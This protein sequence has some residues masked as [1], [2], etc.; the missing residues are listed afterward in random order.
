MSV[1]KKRKIWYMIF[2]GMY[3]ALG[4]MTYRMFLRQAIS[5]P[6]PRGQYL[7]DLVMHIA[8]GRAGT[9]YSLMEMTFGFLMDGLGLNE[10]SVAVLL[11]LLVLG[12]V[13]ATWQ[14]MRRLWPEGDPAV[15][16][17]LAFACMFVAPIYIK[18]LNPYRYIGVQSATIWHNSTY[19]GMRFVGMCVLFFYFYY[20]EHYQ[21]EFA[22]RSFLCFTFLLTLVN[23]IKP[24]FL[25]AFAP[26][27][28][29]MLLTDC[30][31]SRGRTLK[32]Q[33]LFG[34]PVLI[35]LTALIYETIVLFGESNADSSIVLTFA[36]SLRARAA[37][38]IA[39]LL[40]SAAFPLVVLAANFRT[41]KTD[42]RIRVIWLIWLFGLLE[43][44]FLSETG[45]R[46]EHGNLTWGYA[47]CLFLVF[48]SGALQLYQNVLRLRGQ[49]RESGCSTFAL[50]LRGDTAAAGRTVYICAAVLLF[51]AHLVCGLQYS[52][53]MYLGG[54][55]Y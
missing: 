40:Q 43:Y 26:A 35:S 15:L 47:F 12:T 9:G 41:L 22:P 49:Y 13:W 19:T 27:M 6:G 14:T 1:K 54:S 17:L 31:A 51:A 44:L 23:L 24:N 38:P 53:I 4:A 48:V 39:S 18:A 50:Y 42:R 8:E 20:Q 3:A 2:A 37:H 29:V 25:L 33:I 55:F 21:Q 7:S 16:Q 34:I 32:R 46:Q 30:I 11:A 28:A 36:E 5:Y 45:S 10:K 52:W